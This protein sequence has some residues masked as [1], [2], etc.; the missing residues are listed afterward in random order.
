[1]QTEFW[2]QFDINSQKMRLIAQKRGKLVQILQMFLFEGY[3]QR[4]V[5]KCFQLADREGVYSRSTLAIWAGLTQ[6]LRQC[7]HTN[8]AVSS[9]ATGRGRMQ[10]VNQWAFEV[11]IG[12]V[13][14]LWGRLAVY[15]CLSLLCQIEPTYSKQ[16]TSPHIKLSAGKQTGLFPEMLINW[17][18]PEDSHQH[19]LPVITALPLTIYIFCRI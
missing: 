10:S 9:E 3:S 18:F 4:L 12:G 7:V 19:D 13:C 11:L 1:M 16:N 8:E 5:G 15:S 6:T 17:Q 2:R 14:Y